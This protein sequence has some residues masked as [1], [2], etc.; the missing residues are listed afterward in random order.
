[1]I[2]KGKETDNMKTGKF[3]G[4]KRVLFAGLIC[5]LVPAGDAQTLIDYFLPMPIV[6]PLQI[7]QMGLCND[8]EEGH[9]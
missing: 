6:K 4:C 1:M 9:W 2:L 5:L 3:I 7:R 8:R